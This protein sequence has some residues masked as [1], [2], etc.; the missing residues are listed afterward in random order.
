MSSPLDW[1]KKSKALLFTSGDA[2]ISVE[3][4]GKRIMHLKG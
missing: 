4:A 1:E 2:K 3:G